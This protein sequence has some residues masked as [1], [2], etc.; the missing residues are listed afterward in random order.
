MESGLNARAVDYARFC[1][2][3]TTSGTGHADRLRGLG[4]CGH[5][6]RPTTGPASYHGYGYFW[7]IDVERPGRYYALGKYGNTSTWLPM[8]TQ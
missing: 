1:S 6:R 2:P 3:S 8:R 5:R 7:W 4:A